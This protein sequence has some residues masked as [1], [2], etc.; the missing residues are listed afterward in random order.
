MLVEVYLVLGF[1]GGSGSFNPK[2]HGPHTPVITTSGDLR[3]LRFQLKV[4]VQVAFGYNCTELR[5]RSSGPVCQVCFR[6]FRALWA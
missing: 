3:G 4:Q 5:S 1:R 2:M 6:G